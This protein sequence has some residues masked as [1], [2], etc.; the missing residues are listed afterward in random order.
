MLPGWPTLRLIIFQVVSASVIPL[1]RP[2]HAYRIRRDLCHGSL[3]WDA[4]GGQEVSK[5][6]AEAEN[7]T[8]S[9]QDDILTLL[10]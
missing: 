5:E 4:D 9:G 2:L 10:L 1:S 6:S 8:K 7:C 3:L